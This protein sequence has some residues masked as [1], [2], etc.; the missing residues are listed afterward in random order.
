MHDVWQEVRANQGDN[1]MDLLAGVLQAVSQPDAQG[2]TSRRA[3]RKG[4]WLQLD[5]KNLYNNIMMPINIPQHWL[6]AWID[7]KSGK[8]HL[9]DCSREYGKG[10]RGTITFYS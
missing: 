1:R 4:R 2:A 5:L 9:L 7:V 6:L 8:L 10:W 3:H